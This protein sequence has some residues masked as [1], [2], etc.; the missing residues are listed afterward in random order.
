MA[1]E[2]DKYLW[3]NDISPVNSRNLN[4]I[5]DGIKNVTVFA[6][7][8]E[9]AVA[10]LIQTVQDDYTTLDNKIDN[11]VRILQ[12]NIDASGHI[13][14][15]SLDQEYILEAKLLDSN[16]N[17]ISET[18]I[19]LPLESIV[20]SADYYDTYE[21]EGVVYHQVIVLILSTTSVPTIIPVG[22][23]V[24]GLVDTTTAQTITGKKTF[25]DIK[26][27]G[28]L[29]I[30]SGKIASNLIPKTTN[31]YDI[32]SAT[33]CWKNIFFKGSLRD[34]KNSDY[35]FVLPDSTNLLADST[36]VDTAS[37][38]TIYGSKTF[39]TSLPDGSYKN[40]IESEG[41]TIKSWRSGYLSG[42]TNISS[43][44]IDINGINTRIYLS[45]GSGTHF[46]LYDDSGETGYYVINHGPDS[47]H[48]YVINLPQ[49]SGTLSLLKDFISE[50]PKNQSTTVI[51]QSILTNIN[52][53]T[54]Q[55]YTA[56]LNELGIYTYYQIKKNGNIL[57]ESDAIEYMKYMTGSEFLPIYNYDFPKNTLFIFADSSIW[58]PQYDSSNGLLVYRISKGYVDLTNDQT[59]AGT[60]TF[61]DVINISST[62]ND[63][64]ISFTNSY[65][66][67][68]FRLD[69][70][71]FQVN[72]G[73]AINHT[74][75]IST[76]GPIKPSTSTTGLN[77]L[78]ASNA[79]WKDLYLSGNIN[80]GTGYISSINGEIVVKG[81]DNAIKF[82]FGNVSGQTKTAYTF[83]PYTNNSQD[84]GTS[85]YAWKDLYLAGSIKFGNVTIRYNNA[86]VFG[87][88]IIPANSDISLGNSINAWKN[89]YLSGTIYGN[90]RSASFD[91]IY[92]TIF[93]NYST[94]TTTQLGFTAITQLSISSDT[95]FTL[96][97]APTS[98][99]PEYKAT[100][101]NS[102]ASNIVLTF[103]GVTSILTNDSDN[104]IISSNTITLTPSTTI[105]CSIVN[106]KMVA[107]VF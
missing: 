83:V 85:S 48:N 66:T 28:D 59:I 13:L 24:D 37:N 12:A 94:D 74:D 107:V 103:T 81:S 55:N 17:I 29:D 77:D 75:G 61:T 47:S 38:Q 1:I 9:E 72:K 53:R 45:N 70:A 11:Q 97:S 30:S 104:V 91:G 16:N 102:A 60:K 19:D 63:S 78:G 87:D 98:C 88:D 26:I 79:T 43:N 95:T 40:K 51:V 106:G 27:N 56:I 10:N 82:N 80:I 42:T 18:S 14:Q 23:L 57:T 22:A 64:T 93:G 68:Y 73:L 100:I 5:E 105:E 58:K 21:Y 36:L 20:V 50:T 71:L 76:T 65:T 41:I 44:G 101:T 39:S 62:T 2:Y 33:L 89:L 46:D 8:L 52:G 84:L 31:I 6:N 67:G 34:G 86:L 92:G 49:D 35:G 99:Y 69:G 15:L 54:F 90:T 96:A 7:T 4:H 32:G 3:R 25:T